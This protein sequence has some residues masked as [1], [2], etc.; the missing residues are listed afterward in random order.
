MYKLCGAGVTSNL[1]L[2]R[3][4]DERELC[5]SKSCLEYDDTV[6]VIWDRGH[7][8]FYL[9]GSPLGASIVFPPSRLKRGL[10]FGVSLSG[11]TVVL[12]PLPDSLSQRRTAW[13]WLLC[14]HKCRSEA[15]C[16]SEPRLR[17]R[18][19]LVKSLLSSIYHCA[20]V[21]ILVCQFVIF[22]G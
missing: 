22:S 14:L 1:S 9:S 2:Y 16:D 6:S 4:G 8:S 3:H 18:F 20:D 13:I 12:V 19:C 5:A 11:A 10:H 15:L 7:V 17:K 21:R